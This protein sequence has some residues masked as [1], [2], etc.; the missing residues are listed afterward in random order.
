MVSSGLY[1]TYLDLLSLA[2]KMSDRDLFL[3]A[4]CSLYTCK[5]A[6]RIHA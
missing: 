5:S 1:R 3:D 4:A 6:S 2:S